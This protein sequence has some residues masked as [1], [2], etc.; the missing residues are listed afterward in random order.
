VTPK[1]S[2][3]IPTYY[4]NDVLPEAIESVLDQNYEPTEV[5]VVDDSGEGNAEPVIAEYDEVRGIIREENGNWKAALTTG[6][7]VHPAARRRRQALR[8]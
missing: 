6:I 5:I 3:I 1:I 4:R 2:I 7:E 8:S